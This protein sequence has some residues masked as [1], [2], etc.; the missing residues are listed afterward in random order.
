[1]LELKFVNRG[2]KENLV[3]VPGWATDYRIFGCLDLPYNYLL[4]SSYSPFGFAQGLRQGLEKN[5]LA[6][7]SI[8]GWS[9]GGFLALDFSSANCGM[10][11]ELFLL[12]MRKKY[13][14]A[15]LREINLKLVKNK[16]AWLYKF[17]QDLFAFKEAEGWRWFKQELLRDYLG[18]MGLED[19][20]AGLEYLWR[21]ELRPEHFAKINKIKI[22]H[23]AQDTVAPLAEA[24]ELSFYQERA[25]FIR[26]ENSGHALFFN[27]D[28]AIGFEENGL[29]L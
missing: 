16:K 19:L 7:A 23:G 12:G 26:L 25:E 13:P 17:Y 15:A 22:F 6:A 11:K 28:F 21:P 3:L 20:I 1:M 9:M 4:P 18:A 10:V 14:Q 8:L 27:P 24:E 2:Y 29:N 5:G